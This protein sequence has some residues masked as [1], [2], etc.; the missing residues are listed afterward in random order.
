MVAPPPV[1]LLTELAL[2]FAGA[3][4]KSKKFSR[5]Y[6]RV[7]QKYGCELLDAGEVVRPS[8]R[9]GIHLEAEEHRKL[10]NAVG[11]IV[12]KVLNA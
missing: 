1:G 10:G 2:M 4:E 8:D 12:K 7:A 9:D 11:A 6:H 5:Q 3:E